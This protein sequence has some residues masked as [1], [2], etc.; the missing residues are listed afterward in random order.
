[1]LV[2]NTVPILLLTLAI[3]CSSGS[4][5]KEEFDFHFDFATGEVLSDS[6]SQDAGVAEVAEETAT[7]DVAAPDLPD[8]FRTAISAKGY[9][10]HCSTYDDCKDYGLSCYNFG[11]DDHDPFCSSKCESNKDCSLYHVCDYKLGLEKPLRVCRQARFCSTCQVDS[12]C[13]LAGMQCVADDDGNRF[14][15]QKCEPGTMGCDDGSHCVFREDR[16]DWYCVPYWGSCQGDGSQCSPCVIDQDC[17]D[18]NYIC[19]DVWEDIGMY[20][21]ERYCARTCSGNTDCELPGTACAQV[22]ESTGLCLMV[23]GDYFVP[24]CAIEAADFCT[25]CK[26]DYECKPGL[27]CYVGP[28]NIGHYCST[29]C[30]A[31]SECPQGMFCKS[32]FS[33]EN[34]MPTGKYTCALKPGSKCSQIIKNQKEE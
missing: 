32:Q 4:S 34:G 11:T 6:A 8:I 12:Q 18:S 5:N 1:M 29:E 27:L 21:H 20:S 33:F 10:E 14:C 13:M 9:G 15:S 30:K 26:M 3:A 7:P 17:K 31:D 24:T 2:K 25:S 16:Q 28:Q 19:M 23:Y 22:D